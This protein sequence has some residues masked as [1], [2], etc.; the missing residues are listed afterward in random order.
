M[1]PLYIYI[2]IYTYIY[3]CENEDLFVYDYD[4]QKDK[5]FSGVVKL[6]HE[7]RPRLRICMIGDAAHNGE[8]KRLGI[9]TIDIE[10][11][12]SIRRTIKR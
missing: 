9:D 2:Y 1:G 7:P 11:I 5:R 6:P 12:G 3:I 4:P 10:G 8:A